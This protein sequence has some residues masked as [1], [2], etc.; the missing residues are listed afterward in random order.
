M[1]FVRRILDRLQP[2]FGEGGRFERLYP[3]YEGVDSFLYSPGTVTRGKTHLRDSL[4]T[5]RMMTTV[6]VA[7]LPC[8]VMAL[9]NTGFQANRVLSTDDALAAAAGQEWRGAHCSAW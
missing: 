2:H 6:I 4:D 5:K 3:L 8:V 7:L 1:R 9:W